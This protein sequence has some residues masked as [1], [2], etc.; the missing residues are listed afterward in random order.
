MEPEGS[1]LSS[2]EPATGTSHPAHCNAHVRIKAHGSRIC[3]TVQE[4]WISNNIYRGAGIAQRYSAEQRAGWSGF[5]VSGGAG[6][7]SL[8]HRVQNGSGAHPAPYQMCTRGSLPG[9]KRP[10]RESA[11]SPPSSAEVK[12]AWCYTS[13]PQYAFMSWY[14]VK[15]K[16]TFTGKKFILYFTLPRPPPN[17]THNSVGSDFINFRFTAQSRNYFVIIFY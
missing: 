11:H 17:C 9:G 3:E 14:S 2:Q 10:G 4:F 12:S 15:V 7:F 16:T 13:T 1:L 5:R 6:N 8:Q